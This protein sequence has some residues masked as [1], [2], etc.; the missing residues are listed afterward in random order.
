MIGMEV[1]VREGYRIDAAKIDPLRG[2]TL[3]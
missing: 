2:F 3:R 1:D